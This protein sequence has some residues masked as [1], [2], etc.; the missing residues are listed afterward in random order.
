MATRGGGL[1]RVLL[2]S[3][4]H[5]TLRR[6]CRPV[7]LVRPAVPVPGAAAVGAAAA[8]PP[9]LTLALTGHEQTLVRSGLELLL[10]SL[11]REEHEAGAIHAL[12]ARLRVPPAEPGS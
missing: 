5:E 12:L 6:T 7:L 3:V 1:T 8:E 4:A 2:G 10:Y 9:A 11:D